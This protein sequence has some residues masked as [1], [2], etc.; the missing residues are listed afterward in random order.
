MC[1]N[2]KLNCN[3]PKRSEFENRLSE[4]K[5]TDL[6]YYWPSVCG[7]LHVGDM[8]SCVSAELWIC[9]INKMIKMK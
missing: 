8:K 3:I 9:K 5:L 6:S 2:C 7:Q 4:N 1:S